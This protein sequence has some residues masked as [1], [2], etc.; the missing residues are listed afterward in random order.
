MA[1]RIEFIGT[2]RTARASWH[3]AHQMMRETVG[4]NRAKNRRPEATADAAEKRHG[5][6]GS[7]DFAARNGVLYGQCQNGHDQPEPETQ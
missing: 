1:E 3:G 5:A 4:Q 7:T 6:G 2:R